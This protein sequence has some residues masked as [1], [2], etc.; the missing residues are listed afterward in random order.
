[1]PSFNRRP[2]V[3]EP[4]QENDQSPLIKE[5]ENYDTVRNAPRTTPIE[6]EQDVDDSVEVISINSDSPA[7]IQEHEKHIDTKVMSL[8][9]RYGD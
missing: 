3:S 8:E 2:H 5:S 6:E 4:V 1:M 9:D 7:P